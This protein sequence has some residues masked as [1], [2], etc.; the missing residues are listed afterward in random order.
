MGKKLGD[1]WKF[2][3]PNVEKT[4]DSTGIY[5]VKN[6]RGGTQYVG[7]SQNLR[8]RLKQHLNQQDIPG[9]DGFQIRTVRSKKQ[10]ENLEG[11]YIRRLKPKYNVLKHK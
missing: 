7:I 1:T 3:K 9:A 4:P 11:N 6:R 10:A 5:V 2:N 8:T